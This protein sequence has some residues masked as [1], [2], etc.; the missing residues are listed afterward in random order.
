MS[1][2]GPHPKLHEAFLLVKREELDVDGTVRLV[3]GRR[4]PHD[5]ARVVNRGLGQ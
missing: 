5:Q 3:D 4:L 2:V 1:I